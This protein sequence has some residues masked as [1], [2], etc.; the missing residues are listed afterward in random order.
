MIDEPYN[1]QVRALFDGRMHLAED[2]LELGLIDGISEFTDAVR[3]LEK[4]VA[5]DDDVEELA[6]LSRARAKRLI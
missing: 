3:D 2:A 1:E 4:A 6:A 5:V